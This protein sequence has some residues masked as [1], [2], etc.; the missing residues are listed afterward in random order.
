MLLAVWPRSR[1]SIS[2]SGIHQ[3]QLSFF[4]WSKARIDLL[5]YCS[6]AILGFAVDEEAKDQL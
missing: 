3:P 5:H 1:S 4:T 2:L 6:G